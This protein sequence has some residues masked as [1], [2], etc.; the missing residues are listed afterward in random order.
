M[1]AVSQRMIKRGV[2]M[3]EF[4]QTTSNL[5]DSSSNL[6]ELIKARN[7]A[8]YADEA[9]RL[10]I[11]Q[12][13]AV[14]T[15]RGWRIAK[16]KQRHKIDFVVAL[17]MACHAAVKR[18]PVPFAGLLEHYR[19][20]SEA[21]VTGTAPTLQQEHGHQAVLQIGS[22]P[23]RPANF[24]KVNIVTTCSTICGISGHSYMTEPDEGG[25]LICW[26]DQDDAR[27]MIG[28]ALADPNLRAANL[29]LLARLG[30]L[31]PQPRGIRITDLLQAAED[32][33]PRSPFD[34]GGITND[35]LRMM[36]RMK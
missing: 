19:R 7:I 31:P 20:Q 11:S 32:A 13:V 23:K 16:E 35:T 27:V 9:S 33:R 2:P 15:P 8:V 6:Y 4:P 21:L 28:S 25:N 12:A 34:R 5:T 22:K 17:G 1:S 18:T 36:G 3:E 29:D 24:V 10:S 30:N 26:M 14:E